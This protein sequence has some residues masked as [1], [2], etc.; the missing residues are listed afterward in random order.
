MY[1]HTH[2]SAE[3]TIHETPRTHTISVLFLIIVFSNWVRVL[4]QSAARVSSSVSLYG[5]L[6]LA[7][8]TQSVL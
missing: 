7:L 4:F 1:S 5:G 2:Y 8:T 6:Q 3:K